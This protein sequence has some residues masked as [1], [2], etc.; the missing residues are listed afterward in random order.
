MMHD[1]T[2]DLLQASPDAAV[3]TGITAADCADFPRLA[4]ALLGG[5]AAN[6]G[7][8]ATVHAAY[9]EAPELVETSSHDISETARRN[10]EP[11]GRAG[12][13]LFSRGVQAVMAHRVAHHL[14][15]KG[16]QT[17]AMALKSVLGR[18]LSTDIHPAARIGPGLWLDHGLGCVIG[19]TSVIGRDVSIWHN[20]TLGSTLTDSG[21]ERHPKV[22][23]GAVIGAGAV[24]L[25][26]IRVGAGA[27]VGAGA[28]V[29]QDVPDAMTVAG[30]RGEIRG[31]ARVRFAPERS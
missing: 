28:V 5:I 7:V 10:F 18:A 12:A 30:P 20:V 13:L 23:D 24:I 1:E 16:D 3:M 29:L 8:R 9:A 6:D 2:R 19:E 27:N 4:G 22:G 31:P 11:G 15:G 25:G 21:P 14:W 17:R 26:N